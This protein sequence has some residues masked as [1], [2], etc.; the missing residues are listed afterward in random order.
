MYKIAICI[1]DSKLLAEVNS[2]IHDVM[3]NFHIRHK[4]LT[5]SSGKSILKAF[6]SNL[7]T[8][9]IIIDVNLTDINGIET[10]KKLRRS[11]NKN[12][13]I[14]LSDDKSHAYATIPTDVFR[15]IL[16][17]DCKEVLTKS[18]MLDYKRNHQPKY[19]LIKVGGLLKKVQVSDISY[20][21]TCN[22]GTNIY[23]NNEPIYVS[24]KLSSFIETLPKNVFYRCH[25]S[26]AVN[27]QK[28]VGIKR[29][30]AVLENGVSV[31]ISKT[32]YDEVKKAFIDNIS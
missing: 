18:I 31:P 29:Y 8:D 11:G 26:F 32:R 3:E 19:T 7:E 20:L 12:S 23:Y 16:K 9:I 4:I 30:E 28:V 17:S 13:V 2:L 24:L 1:G 14:Y 15:Y 5:F 21:E 22:R 6:E 25:F 27:I 10:I